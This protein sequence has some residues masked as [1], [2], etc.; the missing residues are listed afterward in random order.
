LDDLCHLA[1]IL[2]HDEY[3]NSLI[4]LVVDNI[5]IF[6]HLSSIHTASKLATNE[7]MDVY[8]R[9]IEVWDILLV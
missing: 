4:P 6:L 3:D 9:E 8:T 7:Q 2:I 5:D 1:I